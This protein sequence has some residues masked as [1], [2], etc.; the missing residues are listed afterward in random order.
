MIRS[1]KQGSAS[2]EEVALAFAEIRPAHQ[3]D[4]TVSDRIPSTEWGT[5]GTI[6][7]SLLN[8]GNASTVNDTPMQRP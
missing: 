5:D 2:D 1:S 6:D 4:P 3:W 7:P 8:L